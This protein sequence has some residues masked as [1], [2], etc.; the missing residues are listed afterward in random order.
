MLATG[1]M[2]LSALSESDAQLLWGFAAAGFFLLLILA[3][4]ILRVRAFAYVGSLFFVFKVVRQFWLFVADQS[5]LL[6]AIGIVVGLLFIWVAA[7]FEARRSHM[8]A[9][10]NYWVDELRSWA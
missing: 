9:L 1:L 8:T 2:C 6:W 5:F 4:L 3:G 10:L 7:T